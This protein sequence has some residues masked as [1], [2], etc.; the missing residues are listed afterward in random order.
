MFDRFF[1]THF[2]DAGRP[3]ATRILW[4]HLFWIFGHP[5]VY[6]LIL[7]AMGIV[8]EVL[9][10]FARKPLFGYPVVV[11]SGIHRL[12]RLRRVE[13]PHVRRRHGP[14]GRRG[15]LVDHDAD[16]RADRREDLQ[17]DLATLWGGTLRFTTRALLRGRLHRLFTIG[18]LSG[19]MHASPPVDLQQTDTYFVVAHFHYVLFGGASSGSSRGIYYWWPKMTGRMLDERLGKLHFWLM[20]VGFNLTF[21]P[22][23]YPRACIGMPR[24]IYTYAPGLGWDFWNMS[25]P[26]ARSAS[27][28]SIL[29]FIVNVFA[30]LAAARRRRPTRGTAR[31]LEWRDPLA[32]AGVQL[33][34]DPAGLRSRHA[35]GAR[36]TATARAASLRRPRPPA[37]DRARHPHAAAVVLA[38]S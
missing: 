21:F 29:V 9:P 18:G 36:S 5:E 11:Y 2:Y 38:A 34:R 17:L 10:T 4:Q 33:R 30:T 13:P 23:H 12:L 35:S 32:A 25:P 3:A 14:G 16:R 37:P 7:P 6:I 1:G 22:M 24:R 31:T 28:S 15:L 8:S 19:V 20:F 27:R 26:S